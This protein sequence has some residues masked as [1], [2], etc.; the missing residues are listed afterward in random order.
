MKKVIKIFIAIFSIVILN[1]C[2]VNSYITSNRNLSQTQVIL[3][4]EKFRIL[5]E[6]SGSAKATYIFGI[7]GLSKKAACRNA[8]SEMYRQARLVGSQT[9]TNIN[10][11]QHVGGVFPFYFKVEYIATGQIVE[12]LE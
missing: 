3:H 4:T 8:V 1:G 12:F 6:A 7:G 11:H 10:V 5:G 2:G 9:I